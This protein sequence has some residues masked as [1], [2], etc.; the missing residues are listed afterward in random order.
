MQEVEV[1]ARLRH[2]EVYTRRGLLTLLWHGD[3]SERR[4]VVT[5]GGAVGSV[6]GPAHGLFHDLGVAL[7]DEHGIGTIRIGYRRPNDLGEC[8][9][10][11]A[12]AVDLA[13]RAG[14]ERF[15]TIGHSF[16]G[17]VAIGCAISLPEHVV[18]VATLSTQSA[19]CEGADAL[20]GKP[21]L[22][23]HGDRDELLPPWCSEVVNDLAGGTGEV[24]ILEGAGHL[25]TQGETPQVVRRRLL[26]WLPGVLSGTS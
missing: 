8:V 15:V 23:L 13:V 2:V 19:G 16:G 12:A 1:G 17:A 11:M 18:G 21:L 26:E 4:Y 3:R 9:L 7:D 25:L 6:L 10:D 20:A 22:L 5:G 24:V 14:G